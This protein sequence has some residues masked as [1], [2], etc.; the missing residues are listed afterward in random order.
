MGLHPNEP[1][2]DY[3]YRRFGISGLGGW[4]ILVQIGLYAT[5]FML[6]IQFFGYSLPL[7]NSEVWGIF[8]ST[9]SE[10]YHPLW[11]F[12]IVLEAVYNV[13]I[14]IFSVYILINF[15]RKKSITPKLMIIFY[16]SN[17]LF[18]II[19]YSLF[20]QIP[21]AREIESWN[22]T[23]AII[24][25]VISSAIWCAYFVKSERVRNTFVNE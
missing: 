16:C 5:I 22:S 6:L 24:R 4:L 8:T 17:T 23:G 2:Y 9:E 14:V 19:D 21:F 10:Y 7:F 20:Y 11:G 3:D 25:S 1:K 18:G 13:A 15:Y 12:I